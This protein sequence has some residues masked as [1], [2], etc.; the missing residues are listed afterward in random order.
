MAFQEDQLKTEEHYVW[1]VSGIY[2][3]ASPNQT[4]SLTLAVAKNE[5]HVRIGTMSQWGLV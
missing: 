3:F 5:E 4:E 2:L 1:Y